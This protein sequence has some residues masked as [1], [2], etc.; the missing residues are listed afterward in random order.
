MR[1]QARDLLLLCS[2]QAGKSQTAAA[3]AIVAALLNERSLVLLL[4]PSLRQSSELFQD[5]VMPLYRALGR[6]L[7]A[8]Q[9]TAL[10]L[11]LSNRSRIIS[12]PGNE[13]TI[14]GYSGVK[15][16][17]IDEAARVPDE[18]YYSVRPM[19]AR[20]AGRLVCLTT[21]FGKRGFFYEAWTNGGDAWERVQITAS[22]CAWA[23]KEYLVGERR[24]MGER[25]FNQEYNC[26]FEDVV[27]AV[28]PE[29][30]IHRAFNAPWADRGALN[31]EELMHGD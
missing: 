4:S 2:R 11:A 23:S 20:S 13:E 8:T 18:L 12:L 9:E 27:G 25:W 1:S 26:S 7:E 29:E 15:L 10:R 19:L 17:V 6:P 28:F 30:L 16:L 24:A 3:L 31:L 22:E 21:P 5:K 14:R